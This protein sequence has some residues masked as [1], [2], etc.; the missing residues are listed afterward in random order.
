MPASLEQFIR[1]VDA[2]FTTTEA[3]D[4]IRNLGATERQ[5]ES[6]FQT[7]LIL[8]A[9]HLQIPWDVQLPYPA[10]R[11]KLDVRVVVNEGGVPI[12]IKTLLL[13]PQDGQPWRFRN[14]RNL[15]DMTHVDDAVWLSERWTEPSHK[16]LCLLLAHGPFLERELEEHRHGEFLEHTAQGLQHRGIG[17]SVLNE[18]SIDNNP[19]LAV[20]WIAVHA[21]H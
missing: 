3:K 8:A 18:Y 9:H 19:D 12:E 6:W 20:F 10:T 14:Y 4:Y 15:D 16:K 13:G 21:A 7:R 11:C 2:C 1:H 17:V 5:N